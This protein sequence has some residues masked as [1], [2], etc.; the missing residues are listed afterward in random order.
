MARSTEASLKEGALMGSVG[1]ANHQTAGSFGSL[2]PAVGFAAG[3]ARQKS[4]AEGASAVPNKP[5][6][7][8]RVPRHEKS[9]LWP[10]VNI[11]RPIL[12]ATDIWTPV[13]SRLH[14]GTEGT[15]TVRPL[16]GWEVEYFSADELERMFDRK[17]SEITRSKDRG[18]AQRTVREISNEIAEFATQNFDT[19]QKALLTPNDDTHE[20]LHDWH[21][22]DH[23]WDRG[24]FPISHFGAVGAGRYVMGLVF[25]GEARSAFYEER[26][27]TKNYLKSS[28]G[29]D[30]SVLA[31]EWEPVIPVLD[32]YL[33]V[34]QISGLE[35]P[36]LPLF[37]HLREPGIT[38]LPA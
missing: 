17:Y 10:T 1:F 11:G 23:I 14:D 30:L 7:C 13:V 26:R 18:R 25:D 38:Y 22:E 4:V 29:F 16:D 15:G 9:G 3:M 28:F 37:M 27:I 32:T 36:P 5:A 33:P 31:K 6:R 35:I 19:A 2:Q 21:K 8:Q 12:A 24:S 34:D 20:V